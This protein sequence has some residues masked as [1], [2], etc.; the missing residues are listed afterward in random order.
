M[1][2]DQY[3]NKRHINDLAEFCAGG[4]EVG[5]HETGCPIM[6]RQV[7]LENGLWMVIK[8]ENRQTDLF[9][10]VVFSADQDGTE[11]KFFGG[12]EDA[13][14]TVALMRYVTGS[15]ELPEVP[16]RPEF[17]GA[18]KVSALNWIHI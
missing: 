18:V 11:S 15:A 13:K 16:V 5:L 9:K 10:Y 12:E 17:I 14:G 3:A 7:D 6:Q 1:S 4:S 2:I 8:H